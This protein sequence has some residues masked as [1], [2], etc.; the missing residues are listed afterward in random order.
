MGPGGRSSGPPPPPAAPG[1]LKPPTQPQGPSRGSTSL[2][3]TLP[4]IPTTDDQGI[5]PQ[6]PFDP[7][8][9][10]TLPETPP[11]SSILVP[12]P[13]PKSTAPTPSTGIMDYDVN[14]PT[15]ERRKVDL[16]RNYEDAKRV[17]I[18]E[19]PEVIMLPEGSG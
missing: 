11:S 8:T 19:V 15:N 17:R 10:A 2:P 6:I 14:G 9:P 18:A 3:M 4:P 7:H 12:A 16:N 1:I 5:I 13:I